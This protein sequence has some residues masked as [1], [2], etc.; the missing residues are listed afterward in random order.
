MQSAPA[1]VHIRPDPVQAHGHGRW[2]DRPCGW[3]A[4]CWAA[5]ALEREEKGWGESQAGDPRA[6]AQMRG[7]RCNPQPRSRV[8][9]KKHAGL[10]PVL[11]SQ[12][13][14]R[15]RPSVVF[16]K[17]LALSRVT[18]FPWARPHICLCAQHAWELG[19]VLTSEGPASYWVGEVGRWTS[20]SWGLLSVFS[21]L[22]APVS[23][24]RP[25][26]RCRD[27]QCL[28]SLPLCPRRA[29]RAVFMLQTF[30]TQQAKSGS[31]ACTPP[32]TTRPTP[33]S[34]Y[35]TSWEAEAAQVWPEGW[36][37][38]GLSPPDQGWVPGEGSGQASDC[39]GSA[40]EPAWASVSS[41]VRGKGV[42]GA[43]IPSGGAGSGP[44]SRL[45]AKHSPSLVEPRTAFS[46]AP[47]LP[48]CLRYKVSSNLPGF[49]TSTYTGGLPWWPSGSA[50]GS[51]LIPGLERLPGEGNGDPIQS[52]SGESHGQRCLLGYSPWDLKGVRHVFVTK[53]QQTVH[54]RNEMKGRG[55]GRWGGLAPAGVA[56][57]L[58]RASV[59]PC[60]PLL[61]GQPAHV[62]VSARASHQPQPAVGA[63]AT[64]GPDRPGG[65]WS[66][67]H[68]ET[69]R[70]VLLSLTSSSSAQNKERK[71]RKLDLG[72]RSDGDH[73]RSEADSKGFT[74]S[75]F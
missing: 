41:G 68:F 30:G 47:V 35:E 73:G 1:A 65:R 60:G 49:N 43:A 70:A 39:R 57:G 8:G 26:R 63:L 61:S 4:Q 72:K 22:L 51:G 45:R 59:S 37:D 71:L 9:G 18:A 3:A 33:A 6:Q 13:D 62:P 29:V 58:W 5:A 66:A 20:P 12:E 27:A 36:R 14:N 69:A 38:G 75:I 40:W 23:L 16:H 15:C 2:Q 54:G 10:Y 19:L 42:C 67:R 74:T 46:G 21:F 56:S 32:T 17:G 7:G 55:W 31:R 44:V 52:F 53:Q 64:W 25:A 48:L 28:G 50:R 34:W 24:C 11:F